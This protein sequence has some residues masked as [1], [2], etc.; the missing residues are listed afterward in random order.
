M[1][2]RRESINRVKKACNGSIKNLRVPKSIKMVKIA[3]RLP[4]NIRRVQ[5]I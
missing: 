1:I 2:K 3:K 5:K 4:C